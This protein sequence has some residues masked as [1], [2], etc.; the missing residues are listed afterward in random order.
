M[1][2]ID[3]QGMPSC[4]CGKFL[5]WSIY[6]RSGFIG[7]LNSDRWLEKGYTRALNR[8]HSTKRLSKDAFINIIA[9]FSC[10]MCNRT[11]RKGGNMFNKLC[12]TVR[13]RWDVERVGNR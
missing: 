2:G 12:A 6:S 9:A 5:Y 7:Y 13:A 10:H 4:G 1:S 8:A 3:E 11:I